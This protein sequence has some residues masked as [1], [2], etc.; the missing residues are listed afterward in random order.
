MESGVPTEF[1]QIGL[2]V[3]A[4]LLPRA[5]LAL[6]KWAVVACDQYT[7]QPEYWEEVERYVGD[8]PS[9]LRLIFPEVHLGAGDREERIERI[10]RRMHLYLEQGILAPQ[11]PGFVLVDRQMPQTPSRRGLVAALDLECYDYRP[12]AETLIRAT[13]GTLV[14]RLP[15]R[16]RIREGA[17]VEAPHVMVLIDDPERTVIEPL[18]AQPLE[19]LYDF[20]L[21]QGGGRIRGYRVDQK[22]LIHQ[23]AEGLTRLAD[24]ELERR[25]YGAAEAPPLLYALGDGNHSFAAAKETWERLKRRTDEPGR[26][27][28]HPARHALVELVNVHDE[29]LIFEPIH[30]LVFG[31]DVDEMLR[32]MEAHYRRQG[33]GFARRMFAS[34]AEWEIGC[35]Q[36]D[37]THHCVLFVAEGRFGALWIDDPHHHL[38]VASLQAFLDAYLETRQQARMD[39]IHGEEAIIGLGERPDSVGFLFP[40]VDKGDLFRTIVLDGALP[41]KTF[42]MGE[43][44]EKRYYLECR[45]IVP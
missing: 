17:P 18:A 36:L 2:Q 38:E 26:I 8:A 24:P 19:K 45:K 3:P 23:V 43:A 13:E 35:R 27:A 16:V 42:S 22:R 39:Y 20:A 15:P 44:D 1:S 29:G 7:W 31:V 9:T 34:R 41:R 40:A 25:R 37:S 21:M 12:G 10:H 11:P 30:R 4:L 32:Q 33:I 28:R 14:E 5:D 6:E